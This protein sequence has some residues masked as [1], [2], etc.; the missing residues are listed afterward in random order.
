MCSV[1]KSIAVAFKQLLTKQ[2]SFFALASI[3]NIYLAKAY[4][5]FFLLSVA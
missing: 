5:Y 3:L 4:L 1:T 2:N